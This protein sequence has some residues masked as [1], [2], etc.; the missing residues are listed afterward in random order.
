MVALIT[1]FV[2]ASMSLGHGLTCSSQFIPF[3]KYKQN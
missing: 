1:I 2:F 3:K